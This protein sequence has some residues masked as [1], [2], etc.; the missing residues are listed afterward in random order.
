[1][2]K[3]VVSV[4]STANNIVTGPPSGDETD[5]MQWAQPGIDDSSDTFLTHLANV[6][7]IVLGR[8]TYQDWCAS[9]R[10]SRSGQTCLRSH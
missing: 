1:M 9:G 5:F 2:R 7:T 8:G 3:L 6:D 10:R 4:H